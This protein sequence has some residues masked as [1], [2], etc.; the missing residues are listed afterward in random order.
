LTILKATTESAPL[1]RELNE[2]LLELGLA[3]QRY[4]LYP[5]GHPSIDTAV[6]ALV[7]RVD[8]LLREREVLSLGV[9][10]RQLIV[11]GVATEDSHP[12]LRTVAERLHR[13]RVGVVSFR[14]GLDAAE[15][16]SA[17][18]AVSQDPERGGES[19]G[20]LTAERAAAWPNVRFHTLAYDHLQ[21]A[22]ESDDDDAVEPGGRGGGMA[23]QLWLGLARAALAQEASFDDVE[24]TQ[25]AQAINAHRGARAYDQV[26]VGYM[27]QLTEELK[28]EESAG[29]EAVRSR[30]SQVIRRLDPETLDRLLEMGSD[31]PQR[32]R[33]LHGAA[34]GLQ[35]DAVVEVMTAAARAEGQNI[36]TSLLR[37]LRKLS[38]HAQAASRTGGAAD[39]Q[40]REQVRELLV[41]WSLSDPNPGAY[42]QALESI[43]RAASAGGGA[44]S[45]PAESLRL[46]QMALE[47]GVVGA[48]LL[49]AVDALLAEG[50][51]RELYDALADMP[52][53]NA[54]AQAIWTRIQNSDR[55]RI[56]LTT[57]P[58]DVELLEPVLKRLEPGG[59]IS[60]LLDRL[61]ESESR[62]T[63]MAL[64][65]R[66]TATGLPITPHVLERLDDPRWYVQRNM[67]ALL[68]GVDAWPGSRPVLPYVQHE[69]ERVRREAVHIGVR[70]RGER[71]ATIAS[72]LADSDERVVRAGVVAAREHGLPASAIDTA[73]DRIDDGALSLEVRIALIRLLGTHR[74]P[75]IVE[76]LLPLVLLP[77][78]ML[79]GAR[80]A[81]VDAEMV[82]ALATLASAGGTDPRVA[83]AIALARASGSPV[84]ARALAQRSDSPPAAG[85]PS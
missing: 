70:L 81:P 80:L 46:V 56:V 68:S 45:H 8:R 60:L 79:R 35:P 36:S 25:V 22:H 34:R 38:T 48:A 72:A 53:E 32:A 59:V 28:R 3:L 61:S 41:G 42:T 66:L 71:E 12:V 20:L 84:L 43:S 77:R 39:V 30:V 63:R 7:E 29:V 5:G 52:A 17:L 44:T 11:E 76:R 18:R 21:L 47:V 50:R 64:F 82:A 37:L 31:T 73:L 27:L 65:R 67:L 9:A 16:S 51:L 33:F 74:D 78:K 75:R 58:V 57:D 62:A 6:T 49:R 26:I 10:R 40:L 4:A 2:F 19:L 85:T 15:L 69:E 13:H 23:A 24:P 83:Q 54:A 1:S 14:R 55:I